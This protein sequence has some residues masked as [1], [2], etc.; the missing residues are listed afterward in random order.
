MF[1]CTKLR[2]H[3]MY[4]N[5]EIFS[6]KNVFQESLWNAVTPLQ[7]CKLF[8]H[9]HFSVTEEEIAWATR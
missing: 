9:C 6:L 4:G 7:A 8:Q 5:G 3:Q 1:N 2:M